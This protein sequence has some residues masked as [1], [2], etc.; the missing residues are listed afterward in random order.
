MLGGLV[1]GLGGGVLLAV[2]SAR[3][4]NGYATSRDLTLT[5]PTAA[6]IS[7]DVTIEGTDDWQV[8][9]GDFGKVR[10][11][12]T[13][14]DQTPLFLGVALA[15]DVDRWL[16]G[17]ARDEVTRAWGEVDAPAYRRI[18]GRSARR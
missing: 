9:W 10:V 7:S 18:G 3:D 16:S 5:T 13:A 14:Q 11:T 4:A 1:V 2:D 6:V 15:S 8:R 12:A 17:T